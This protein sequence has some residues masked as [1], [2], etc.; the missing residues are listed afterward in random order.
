MPQIFELELKKKAQQWATQ[1]TNQSK[2]N[3]GK[4]LSLIEVHSRTDSTNG[5]VSIVTTA[6]N[7]KSGKWGVKNVARAYEYGSGVWGKK[8]STYQI[9]PRLKKAL[10]FF[11]EKMENMEEESVYGVMNSPKFIGFT[12]EGKVVFKYVDHPGVQAVKNGRGY[13]KPAID[14]VRRKARPELTALTGNEVRL[15]IRRAFGAK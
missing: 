15:S 4:F 14:K 2:A 12:K 10:A 3:L 7:K 6:S 9:R 1:I 11:W 13:M 5:I 8:K